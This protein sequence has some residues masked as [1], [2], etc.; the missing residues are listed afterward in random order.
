MTSV[1]I[2]LFGHDKPVVGDLVL[3][4]VTDNKK[5]DSKE[6]VEIGEG[7]LELLDEQAVAVR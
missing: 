4:G 5:E 7:E 2:E 3:A 1:R 6:N